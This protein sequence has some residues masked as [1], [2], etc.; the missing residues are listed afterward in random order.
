MIFWIRLSILGFVILGIAPCV[1]FISFLS[2]FIPGLSHMNRQAIQWVYIC[3]RCALRIT[4]IQ[5]FQESP[6]E[7]RPSQIPTLLIANHVAWMD[8]PIIGSAG[9]LAF[10]SKSEVEKWPII[11]FFA[12]AFHTVFVNRSRPTETKKVG[13]AVETFA[14]ETGYPLVLFAEGTTGNGTFILP[15]KSALLGAVQIALRAQNRVETLRLIPLSVTYAGRGGLPTSYTDRLALS[16]TGD[17][18]LW[19]HLRFILTGP[20]LEVI[21]T[22]GKPVIW[23]GSMPRKEIIKVLQDNVRC[24]AQKALCSP[25]PYEPQAC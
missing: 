7:Y 11:G 10:I 23:N 4:L 12:R 1:A 16:W 6:S 13:E 25:I 20:P 9:L 17:T 18:T 22:W 19:P 5:R 15:F 21:L 2:R 14:Q 8:I 3:M 24:N